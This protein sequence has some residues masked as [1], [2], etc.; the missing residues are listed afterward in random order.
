MLSPEQSRL[1]TLGMLKA[2]LMEDNQRAVR[3]YLSAA[4]KLGQDPEE[5]LA[6]AQ[7]SLDNSNWPQTNNPSTD[8]QLPPTT[9]P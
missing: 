8:N 2:A 6:E 1:L 5:L 3:G 4:Q 9:Q 7:K